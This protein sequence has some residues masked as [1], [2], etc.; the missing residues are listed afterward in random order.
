[1]TSLSSYNAV[2]YVH[3]NATKSAISS[4]SQTTIRSALSAYKGGGSVGAN[5][6]K[7]FKA[8]SLSDAKTVFSSADFLTDAK[9]LFNASDVVGALCPELDAAFLI[10]TV[11]ANYDTITRLLGNGPYPNPPA[12]TAAQSANFQSQIAANLAANNFRNWFNF[13]QHAQTLVDNVNQNTLSDDYFIKGSPSTFSQDLDKVYQDFFS[14]YNLLG[15]KYAYGQYVYDCPQTHN[16]LATFINTENGGF[17]S[18]VQKFNTYNS[19][20]LSGSKKTTPTTTDITN[21]NK[22][23]SDIFIL[24]TLYAPAPSS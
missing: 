14:I 15:G 9:A 12:L 17:Q 1:M 11:V 6:S 21:L 10:V 23:I 20:M 7:V 18:F 22:F 3:D 4:A 16:D 19:G 13:L 24:H 8:T 2:Q 5:V